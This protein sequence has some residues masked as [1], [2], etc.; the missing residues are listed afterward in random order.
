MIVIIPLGGIGQR[1]KQNG[2]KKPKALINLY[3]SPIITYLIDNIDPKILDYVF[4][5]YNREY[6]EY[7]LEDYLT[8]LYPDIIFKFHCIDENTR[9]AAETINI[10]LRYLNETQ[11][12]PVLCLDCDNFY[13]IN[14]LEKWQGKNMIFTINDYSNEPVYSYVS[15]NENNQM[16][17]KLFQ[18]F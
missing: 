14:I 9:G 8:Q 4:I 2:Y 16:C 10:G 5:P 11:P 12:K 13:N 17:K 7:R 15:T 6:K 1:F 18:G 3:G